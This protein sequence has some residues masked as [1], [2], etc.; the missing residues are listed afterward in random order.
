ML[1]V[2]IFG[3]FWIE[4]QARGREAKDVTR[5]DIENMVRIEVVKRNE[6]P[7]V[8]G[9]RIGLVAFTI[10]EADSSLPGQETLDYACCW[11][12]IFQMRPY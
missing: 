9:A 2:L 3:W 5:H 10:D 7:M 1:A 8:E 6:G 4:P 12:P 11:L